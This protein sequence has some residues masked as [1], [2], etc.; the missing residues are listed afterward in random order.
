MAVSAEHELVY[1]DEDI[2]RLR[3][4]LSS[5]ERAEGD[6]RVV[7]REEWLMSLAALRARLLGLERDREALLTELAS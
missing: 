1:L 5:K 2:A 3:Q 7:S 6:G 4:R